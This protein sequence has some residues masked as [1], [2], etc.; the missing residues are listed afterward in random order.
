MI[1]ALLHKCAW[2][3]RCIRIRLAAGHDGRVFDVAFCP[4]DSD[5]LAS[6]SDD[7]TLRL[8]QVA[9]GKRS[10]QIGTFTAHTDSVLRAAWHKNGQ[11]LASGVCQ[12]SFPCHQVTAQN[13][14]LL[15]DCLSL[16]YSFCRY[17]SSAVEGS[18]TA[19]RSRIYLF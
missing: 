4:V 3:T 10:R 19:V 11:L 6:A 16:H 13:S 2:C 7:N 15:T 12:H 14:C 5:L 9:D 17:N 18:C 8:W 1:G